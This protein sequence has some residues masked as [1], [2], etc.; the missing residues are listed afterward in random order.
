MQAGQ[1]KNVCVQKKKLQEEQDKLRDAG[2]RLEEDFL[3]MEMHDLAKV[4]DSLA[5][6]TR[7]RLTRFVGLSRKVSNV[8]GPPLINVFCRHERFVGLSRKVSSKLL[9]KPRLQRFV[10]LLQKVS[11][12]QNTLIRGGVKIFDPFCIYNVKE[13]SCLQNTF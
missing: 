2:I 4:M 11:C 12:L 9:S 10:E 1:I 7:K 5:L 3:E 13:V 8:F 6:S